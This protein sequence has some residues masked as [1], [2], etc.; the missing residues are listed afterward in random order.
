MQENTASVQLVPG[1]M[2]RLGGG[3]EEQDKAEDDVGSWIA[4]GVQCG[5]GE[6]VAERAR[7]PRRALA[8]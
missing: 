4:R 1:S 7:A 3:Q 8:R 6:G 5:W 2:M